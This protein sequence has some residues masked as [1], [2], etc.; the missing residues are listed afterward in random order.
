M[1]SEP[2]PEMGLVAPEPARPT[3]FCIHLHVDDADAA[4]R[5][6]E[7]AGATV[8]RPAQDAF[9]GERSGRIRDPFGARVADRP[10]RR[11]RHAGGDAE[12]VRGDDEGAARLGSGQRRNGGAEASFRNARASVSERKTPT[13]FVLPLLVLAE[14]LEHPADAVGDVSRATIAKRDGADA[15]SRCA[16]TD[17]RS[18]TRCTDGNAMSVT[19]VMSTSSS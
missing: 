7:Q 5:R 4:I 13:S 1:L 15:R 8:V 6:A 2:Y 17:A 19:S 3:S 16:A 10:P 18:C 11:G 14:G 12:A 9:Y